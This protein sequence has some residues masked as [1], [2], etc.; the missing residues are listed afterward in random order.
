MGFFQCEIWCNHPQVTMPPFWVS[1][2][3]HAS[4]R[5]PPTAKGLWQREGEEEEKKNVSAALKMQLKV[6]YFKFLRK[7]GISW[8]IDFHIYDWHFFLKNSEQDHKNSTCDEL[9]TTQTVKHQPLTCPR[10]NPVCPTCTL[11]FQVVFAFRTPKNTSRK[12]V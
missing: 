8:K 7:L 6:Y 11:S 5:W 3:F 9:I 10:S 2:C 1:V 12:Y 4:A